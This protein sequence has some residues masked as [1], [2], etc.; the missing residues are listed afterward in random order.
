M[1]EPAVIPRGSFAG[2]QFYIAGGERE[3]FSPATP[4]VHSAELKK[5]DVAVRG[6]VDD[7]AMGTTSA[8]VTCETCYNTRRDC[9]GHRGTV[10]LKAPVVDTVYRRLSERWLRVQCHACGAFLMRPEDR[11]Q[12]P[13]QLPTLARL[14]TASAAIQPRH[15]AACWSCGA[16][17][18]W[19]IK[20]ADIDNV[21]IT[22]RPAGGRGDQVEEMSAAKI[23]Q[24]FES[25]PD[26][27]A[28]YFGL[29]ANTHPARMVLRELPVLPVPMRPEMR[30]E[31]GRVAHDDLTV[32]TQMVLRFNDGIIPEEALNPSPGQREVQRMLATAVRNSIRDDT[33][34]QMSR[35][36][37]PTGKE[38]LK[39][40][41]TRGSN[42]K[43]METR[44]KGKH[45]MIR[46]GQM[47]RRTWYQARAVIAND[48]QVPP[49]HIK[50]PLM[51][52]RT[53]QATEIVN[54]HNHEWLA[55]LLRNGRGQYPG[56]TMVTRR[57]GVRYYV[58]HTPPDFVLQNGDEMLRDLIDGDV[59]MFNRM[60][61]LVWSSGTQYQ[62]SID[63]FDPDS[64]IV[65]MNVHSCVLHN[66][67]FDGDQMNIWAVLSPESR[68]EIEI[69]SGA[70]NMFIGYRDIKPVMGA[71][72]DDVVGLTRLCMAQEI[73]RWSAMQM[74]RS[75]PR[76]PALPARG[77]ARP[78]RGDSAAAR[79]ETLT[80]RELV[81]AQLAA[82][83]V[84]LVAKTR[85]ENP[86]FAPFLE[87]N[88][89]DRR[90]VIRNGRMESGVLDKKVCGQ[91]AR[92]GLFHTISNRHGPAAAL[93]Q[94]F[95]LMQLSIGFLSSTGFTMS[96]GDLYVPKGA[97]TRLREIANGVRAE[98]DALVGQLTAGK[99]VPPIGQTTSQFFEEQALSIMNVHDEVLATVMATVDSRRNQLFN[100]VSSGAKGNP[101]NF[102]ATLGMSGP[103]TV[104]S[105]MV[106]LNFSYKRLFPWTERCDY[107]ISRSF[108]ANSI[109]NG[110]TFHECWLAAMEGRFGF[111]GKALLT[112]VAGEQYRNTAKNCEAVVLDHFGRVQ[113]SERRTLRF[114]YG[115]TGY[116]PRELVEVKMAEYHNSDRDFA[117]LLA[118]DPKLVPGAAALE[119]GCAPA[120]K[121]AREA[122]RE[123][124]RTLRR[125][126]LA[127]ESSSHNAPFSDRVF[128][129]VNVKHLLMGA[130][131]SDGGGGKRAPKQFNAM[132]EAAESFCAELP[133][134]YSCPDMELA[135][136]PG[137]YRAASVALERHVR[138][139]LAPANLAR[140]TPAILDH[141]LQQTAVAIQRAIAPGGLAVGTIAAEVFGEP[142]TQYMLDSLHRNTAG[143]TSRDAAKEITALL[144]AAVEFGR[145]MYVVPEAGVPATLIANHIELTLLDR[146]VETWQIF[147]ED[148]PRT[149]HP[150]YAAENAI[151]ARFAR[152]NP[153]HPPPKDLLTICLRFDLNRVTMRIRNTTIE[154]VVAVIY[155]K[156]PM[157]YVVYESETGGGKAQTATLMLRVYMRR[158]MFTS[159]FPTEIDYADIVDKVLNLPVH[160]IMRVDSTAV[161]QLSRSYITDDGELT[162]RTVPAVRTS[163]SNLFEVLQFPQVDA[164]ET[165]STSI[166]DVYAIF[167][168]QPARL[169]TEHEIQNAI[170]TSSGSGAYHSHVSVYADLIS[171][172]GVPV[173]MLDGIRKRDNR[174]VLLAAS[175]RA[176][177]K[178]FMTASANGTV[179]PLSDPAACSMVGRTPNVGTNFSKIVIDHEAIAKKAK[180]AD[181][182]FDEIDAVIGGIE[183]AA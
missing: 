182:V 34:K 134:F 133:R 58:E 119:K 138:A 130:V 78:A 149:R 82:T 117:A 109:I 173:S 41:Q 38:K 122:L 112:S 162:A 118:L 22:R 131:H 139:A 170:Q 128:L 154:E 92:S 7:P 14:T 52:A 18:L 48:P 88:P 163:G 111:I 180:P 31:G 141:V 124:R 5:D 77:G 144:S 181:A 113:L 12:L 84:D 152:L 104:N 46:S 67:D 19:T 11:P 166:W 95:A 157:V 135:S 39:V 32:L 24:I 137:V 71:H 9:T 53:L 73:S 63:T 49:T 90:V 143:G 100:L 178:N 142:F 2:V 74:A 96:L 28:A 50:V 136:L 65:K 6:G 120:L 43:P 40:A 168:A 160:G 158:Q 13:P 153:A 45:A 27:T 146:F 107:G 75:I 148:F 110:L 8:D 89:E 56:C 79:P 70:E 83:P 174:A 21:T 161:Y 156:Y 159:R 10:L 91:G 150:A 93:S 101:D 64:S 167:G 155:K 47:G 126:G 72:Y 35:R 69:M 80:G 23:L 164:L 16:A 66:A 121:K 29:D 76:P 179:D 86:K 20:G 183:Y 85:L 115:N 132:L 44:V 55:E 36:T 114:L 4:I 68:A 147:A 81:S 105:A 108:I 127:S 175:H 25:M 30:K 60:P 177:V 102:A 1:R 140:A 99:L 151:V 129:P 62:V 57:N 15:R 103:A 165:T 97:Q 169:T 26:E 176:A 106:D 42:I 94:V 33:E 59:V 51:M 171:S 98:I 37:K 172:G 17:N 87:I 54:A 61:S 116:D 145:A 123:A 125:D 3:G